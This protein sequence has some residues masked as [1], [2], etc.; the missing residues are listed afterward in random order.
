MFVDKMADESTIPIINGTGVNIG[1]LFYISNEATRDYDHSIIL[2]KSPWAVFPVRGNLDS[3]DSEYE[4]IDVY[5]KHD[6]V[7]KVLNSENHDDLLFDWSIET[8]GEGSYIKMDPEDPDSDGHHVCFNVADYIAH[9]WGFPFETPVMKNIMTWEE[10]SLKR[11]VFHCYINN[12]GNESH[13]FVIWLH[14][15]Q[16][17]I[18]QGYGGWYKPW[19]STFEIKDWV[20]G[21]KSIRLAKNRF[22]QGTLVLEYF[23]FPQKIFG[24]PR[25]EMKKYRPF[26]FDRTVTCFQIA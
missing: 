15:G 7:V 26:K 1:T 20:K 3:L 13:A 9:L 22:D 2:L 23:G 8:Q 10:L 19:V 5:K 4:L 12:A 17:T 24:T 6:E 25:E 18:Y 11:G 14:E 21:M 16:I